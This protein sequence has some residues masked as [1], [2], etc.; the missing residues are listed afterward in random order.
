M[1]GHL[2]I[3]KYDSYNSL[4]GNGGDAD[5][6]SDYDNNNDN[7]YDIIIYLPGH[8]LLRLNDKKVISATIIT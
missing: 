3:T 4:N 1:L 6:D 7:N 2:C 5:G 8:L